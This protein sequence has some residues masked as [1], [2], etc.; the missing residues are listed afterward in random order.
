MA[1][2][3]ITAYPNGE[4]LRKLDE[5]PSKTPEPLTLSG[6]EKALNEENGGEGDGGGGG[7]ELV[8]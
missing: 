7:G 6:F 2:L 1:V 5:P 4:V 3:F 8:A